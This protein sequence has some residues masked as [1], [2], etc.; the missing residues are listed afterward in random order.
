VTDTEKLETIV[1][2]LSTMAP[3]FK[4]EVLKHLGLADLGGDLKLTISHSEDNQ[5]IRLD[6][7]KPTAWIGLPKDH[8]VQL[9]MLLLQHAGAKLEAFP[10]Q[11]T[12]GDA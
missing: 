12:L 10:R 11:E 3:E 9:A 8:A 1:Q 6:F 4:A 5:I 2:M 7:G